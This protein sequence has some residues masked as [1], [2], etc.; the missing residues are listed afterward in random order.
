MA[1]IGENPAIRSG[2][3]RRIVW[4]WAAATSSA[5]SSHDARTKPPL[6]R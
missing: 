1:G 3:Y 2:P 5:A 4:T 6:P